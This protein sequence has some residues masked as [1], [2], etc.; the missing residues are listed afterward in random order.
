M[1]PTKHLRERMQERNFNM[2][3]VIAVLEN[4]DRIKPVWN[5]NVECWNYDFRGRDVDGT[6][7]TIRIVPTDDEN[8]IVLVTGF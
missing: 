8:G 3:D 4:H 2:S 5:D 7:L 6:E 1:I